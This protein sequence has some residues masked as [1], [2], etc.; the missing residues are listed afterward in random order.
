MHIEDVPQAEEVRSEFERLLGKRLSDEAFILA[1][2]DERY[3]LH[4]IDAR[5][6][7][8]IFERLVASASSRIASVPNTDLGDDAVNSSFGLLVSFGRALTKWGLEGFSLVDKEKQNRRLSA[9][10]CCPHLTD[11]P[12]TPLYHLGRVLLVRREDDSKVCAKCG[13]FVKAKVAVPTEQCPVLDENDP[14]ISRWGE[15]V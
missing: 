1:I 6:Y 10:M 13:C 7:A 15:R 8:P 11:A 9:C 2:S 5:N 4:L 14:S 12:Q 3:R